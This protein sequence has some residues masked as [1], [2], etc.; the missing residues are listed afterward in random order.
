MLAD[1]IDSRVVVFFLFSYKKKKSWGILLGTVR[2]PVM[3]S[4][5]SAMQTDRAGWPSLCGSVHC[6]CLTL[7]SSTQIYPD[8]KLDR[9]WTLRSP[10]EIMTLSST[11]VPL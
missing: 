5:A 4:E 11:T 8:L 1:P 3:R 9:V 7:I 2:F 6:N 10:V